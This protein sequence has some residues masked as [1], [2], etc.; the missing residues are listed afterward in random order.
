MNESLDEIFEDA[1]RRYVGMVRH[2]VKKAAAVSTSE[3]SLDDVVLETFL[4]AWK[5][6]KQ[7]PMASSDVAEWLFGISLSVLHDHEEK[8][9]EQESAERRLQG[10]IA[11]SD[12]ADEIVHLW[13]IREKLDA[14]SA[15]L[16]RLSPEE[17]EVLYLHVSEGLMYM[18][19]AEQLDVA[20][21]T[22]RSRISRGRKRLRAFTLQESTRA[23]W[24]RARQG[25][26]ASTSG[27]DTA[28]V[29]R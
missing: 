7:L 8:I 22:V 5:S 21:G 17:Q 10:R 13:E 28:N 15:A 23:Q 26:A 9:K 4:E 12:I 29:L 14:V 27:H 18:E 6:R 25:Q 1:F 24:R 11:Q 20:I 3:E 16:P 19:M 2:N